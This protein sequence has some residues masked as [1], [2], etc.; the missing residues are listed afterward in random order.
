MKRL[1]Q[2]CVLLGIGLM[3]MACNETPAPGPKLTLTNDS[4]AVSGPTTPT[5][6]TTQSA[7]IVSDDE[8]TMGD[9][10]TCTGPTDPMCS[11]QG[12]GQRKLCDVDLMCR[13]YFADDMCGYTD[14]FAGGTMTC[15]YTPC[16]NDGDCPVD[17]ADAE[18]IV[19]ECVF[20]TS[21]FADLTGPGGVC[22]WWYKTCEAMPD[23][24][25]AVEGVM[26]QNESD[27]W[28]CS[29]AADMSKATTEL[30]DAVDNDCDGQTD[31]SF[32]SVDEFCDGPDA[33]GCA[34]GTWTCADNELERECVNEPAEDHTEVCNGLDDNCDGNVD[35]STASDAGTWYA[36]TDADGFGNPN[37]WVKSCGQPSGYVADNTDC[38][39]TKGDVSPADP[40]L[41]S[42]TYDDNC[43]GAVNEST[44]TDAGSW[45]MDGDADG[46]G[47]SGTL[48]K[49]CTQPSGFAGNATDCLD[50]D[51]NVHPGATEWCNGEDDNCDG[52]ADEGFN[53][54]TAC[55]E[56]IG[57]C[58]Q[59][60]TFVCNQAGTDVECSAT[61]NPSAAGPE[62]CNGWDDDCD[63][64]ADEGCDD[65]ADGWCDSA[66]AY[67]AGAACAMGDCLDTDASVHPMAPEQ[68]NAVDNDCDGTAD[69]GCDDDGDGWCD[70]AMQ[71]WPTATCTD[72][73]CVD[74]DANVHP[75]MEEVCSTPYDDNCDGKTDVKLDGTTPA[76]D[77]CANALKLECGVW[78][79][80]NMGT[81]PNTSNAISKY[82]C[83]TKV[84]PKTITST[85]NAPEVIVEP[86]A[87][88]GTE[89]SLQIKDPVNTACAARLHGSCEPNSGT[90]EVTAF[91]DGSA[92]YTG[93]CAMQGPTSVSGGIVGSDFVALDAG[94]A[95][96]L[97][98]MF[99]CDAP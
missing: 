78:V 94:T 80:I 48:M 90:S 14:G 50:S 63:D 53:L 9:P 61:A 70:S 54:A 51:P 56:G 83:M 39:D 13:L 11:A 71:V 77:S 5:L 21:S 99:T 24:P 12:D 25:C 22:A 81:E 23:T 19:A 69:E 58:A 64:T 44:A 7:V 84:G 45:W 17:P 29:A 40:E 89:F 43:D 38:D 52:N 28:V 98:V 3:G 76:C 67:A 18:N 35:E 15:A 86:D 91:K 37:S 87:A 16:G 60:G 66:M 6:G 73:D 55:S 57:V 93:T 92:V 32:F 20:T 10:M 34:T 72:G 33:D 75:A 31:E 97:T 49:S 85:A 41:C 74:T 42:T 88:P 1:N 36:D 82:T 79:T 65:D 62:S 96:T 2:L 4:D 8:A 27:A 46:F 30:C 47:L 59:N 26:Y 68:C 95:Q